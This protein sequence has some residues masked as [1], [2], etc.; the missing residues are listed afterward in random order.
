MGDLIDAAWFLIAVVVLALGGLVWT[1]F[2]MR[3]SPDPNQPGR[4]RPDVG[5][6]EFERSTRKVRR[7]FDELFAALV[8][9]RSGHERET[10]IRFVENF[11]DDLGSEAC[12]VYI[13]ALSLEAKQH[14]SRFLADVSLVRMEIERARSLVTQGKL[15]EAELLGVALRRSFRDPSSDEL[16]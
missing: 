12:G 4:S 7:E 5:E 10:V 16:H 9:R 2:P 6:A 15:L 13:D 3:K 1:M 8:E 14:V 11:G